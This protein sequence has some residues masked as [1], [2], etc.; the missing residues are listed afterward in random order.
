[1]SR[2]SGLGFGAWGL[3]F[4]VVSGLGFRV[5]LGRRWEGRSSYGAETKTNGW[6][7]LFWVLPQ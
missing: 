2:V 3:E 7:A 6:H 1:M 4:R 5:Q